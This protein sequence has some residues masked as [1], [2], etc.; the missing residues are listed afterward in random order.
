MPY[1]QAFL[2]PD[3]AIVSTREYSPVRWNS[4]RATPIRIGFKVFLWFIHSTLARSTITTTTYIPH[5]WN[6]K[7]R[8]TQS[9]AHSLMILIFISR[10]GRNRI[11]KFSRRWFSFHSYSEVRTYAVSAAVYVNTCACV[12]CERFLLRSIRWCVVGTS[13]SICL[14]HSC[15]VYLSESKC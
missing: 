4:C 3:T 5:K 9:C 12:V 7:M 6:S 15:S 11:N 14:S 13:S 10:V 2:L 1:I 8:H